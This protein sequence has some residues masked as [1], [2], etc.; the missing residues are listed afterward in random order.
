LLLLPALA[1]AACA[2]Q[3][4]QVARNVIVIS[5]DTLRADRL[6][7][8]GHEL[9]TS[10]NIDAFAR[11]GVVFEDASSTSPWT[12]P[13]HA[14]L[15]SGLYPPR[16]GV[17][18]IGRVL[19][20]D[21]PTLASIL[22]SQGFVTRAVANLRALQQTHQLLSSFDSVEIVPTDQS[23]T[24]AA[25]SVTRAATSWLAPRRD[26]RTLLFVHY[27]DVHSDYRSRPSY[28]R[29]FTE[30][31][32]DR[33]GSTDQLLAITAGARVPLAEIETL[34]RLY[35][36]GIRQ[37]DEELGRFFAW[38]DEHDRLNDT[39]IVL[40]SDHGEEFF[41]HGPEGTPRTTGVSHGHSLYQELLR[42]P[43]M[44]RGPGVPA[45]GRVTSP[46]SLV[47]VVSTVL[48]TLGLEAPN[49]LDGES[50]QPLFDG[51]TVLGER[52]M[53]FE[54]SRSLR[55]PTLEGVRRGS[56]KLVLDVS[57]GER[58]LYDLAAD[59]GETRDLSAERPEIA[60]RLEEDLRWIQDQRRRAETRELS[61]EAKERLRA[62]GYL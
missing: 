50:L 57:T 15:L 16:H 22:R 43:L 51:R 12:L 60:A 29:V 14:S 56:H 48:D 4:P 35:D 2:E 25:R 40:T 28:E 52:P 32:H 59:P 36:A 20:A 55:T 3:P 47:D 23:E 27:Y 53:F 33:Q 42:V 26:E 24:G 19:S 34:S 44:L 1:F 10:P 9:P 8:Y 45:R 21:L 6:G 54:T 58:A 30:R 49:G 5:V 31:A 18:T 7:C 39:L 38:L 62:L 41:D 11:Q 61:D 46:V 17:R 13:A 37:L